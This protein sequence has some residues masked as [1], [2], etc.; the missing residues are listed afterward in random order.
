MYEDYVS[1][2]TNDR[3]LVVADTL[4]TVVVVACSAALMVA[5]PVELDP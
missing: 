5:L 1:R 2:D 4:S 3:C